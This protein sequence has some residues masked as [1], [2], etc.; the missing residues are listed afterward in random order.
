MRSV[1]MSRLPSRCS[2]N[3]SL[4]KILSCL[5]LVS[6]SAQKLLHFASESR[7]RSNMPRDNENT[8]A[9]R[10]KPH[11]IL[12]SKFVRSALRL[13]DRR[14]SAGR[15]RKVRPVCKRFWRSCPFQSSTRHHAPYW[16]VRNFVCG[17]GLTITL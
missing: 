8:A 2:E 1:F 7:L 14:N 15:I 16:T 5:S 17:A 3:L 6:P 11:L 4:A 9:L 13:A 12:L 10:Q